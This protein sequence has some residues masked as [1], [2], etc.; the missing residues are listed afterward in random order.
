MRISRRKTA[1]EL[2]DAQIVANLGA[3]HFG[4]G[5]KTRMIG[6]RMRHCP[7]NPRNGGDEFDAD[8]GR[9][10]DRRWRVTSAAIVALVAGMILASCVS[11]GTVTDK[12]YHEPHTTCSHTPTL[13]CVEHDE[14]WELHLR[15]NRGDLGEQCVT[16]EAWDAHPVGSYYEAG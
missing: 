12:S 8:D 3:S 10:T 1:Q 13:S 11:S 7:N 2:W 5:R 15:S 6:A 16:K 4:R 14:C 9:W